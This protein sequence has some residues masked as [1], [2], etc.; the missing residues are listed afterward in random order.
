MIDGEPEYK[1]AA[2][3]AI[4]DRRYSLKR[5]IA[6][7]GMGV[8]MEA[9]HQWLAR[10]VALKTLVRASLDSRIAIARLMREARALSLSRHPGVV[11]VLDAGV[12]VLHGPFVALELFE[13]RSLESFVVARARLEVGDVALIA[14]QLGAALSHAHARGVL[15]RDVKSANILIGREPGREGDVVKLLDFGIASVPGDEDVVDRKLT[16]A[17]EVLGTVEYMAPEQLLH[18]LPPTP[19]VD[20]YGLG[21]VLYECLSGDVPIPGNAPA[22][23]TSLLQNVRPKSLR[24]VRPDVP[25]ALDEAILRALAIE[26]ENRFASIEAFARAIDDAVPVRPPRLL[27]HT[28]PATGGA[29]RQWV[30]VPYATPVRVVSSAGP[31]D[32][33]TEDISEGGLLVVANALCAEGEQVVVRLPLP[34]SGR[35]LSLPAIARWARTR[36]GQRALGLEFVDATDDVREEI[37]AY[38]NAMQASDRAASASGHT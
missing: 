19:A 37:R 27:M 3:S 17:Y 2:P 31:S 18:G 21:A 22:V 32:G 33:R 11:G 8:V 14:I 9:Q 29:R 23:M 16:G 10:P 38:V 25:P 35:V 5:E 26:P 4:V 28:A 12:C 7:G 20:V 6:R 34:R 36:R 1:E 30:R 15:H 13:G 24:A